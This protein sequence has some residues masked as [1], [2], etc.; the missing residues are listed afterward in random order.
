MSASYLA[1]LSSIFKYIYIKKICLQILRHNLKF[2]INLN[3]KKFA[4]LFLI[5]IKIFKFII[6]LPKKYSFK[7]QIGKLGYNW[8]I[9]RSEYYDQSGIFSYN[10]Y[11]FPIKLGYFKYK[12]LNN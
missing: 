8:N 6:K 4:Y 12:K 11:Y 2:K 7:L 9:Q 1:K 3:L 5:T 10:F